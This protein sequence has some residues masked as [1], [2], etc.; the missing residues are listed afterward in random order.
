MPLALLLAVGW[1][2]SLTLAQIAEEIEQ[3]IGFLEQE[4]HDL[5][6]R[7]RGIRTVFEPTWNLYT[8]MSKAYSHASLCLQAD[9]RIMLQ[10]T[11]REPHPRFYRA[12]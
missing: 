10:N 7:H 1:S 4:K 5:P 9:A 2:H 12:S 11:S 6:Y 8:F 3:C